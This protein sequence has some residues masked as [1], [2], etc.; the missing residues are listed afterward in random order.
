[1]L[2]TTSD[3]KA[4]YQKWSFPQALVS[5]FVFVV[6]FGLIV[7]RDV[8][9][10]IEPR[11][12]AEEATQYFRT[13]YT[14][15]VFNALIAPHQG[16]YSLW[17]NLAGVLATIPPLERAPDVTTGM[18][19]LVLLAILAAIMLN[20]SFALD[21]PLK[22]AIA[23]LSVV[24]VGATGEIWLTVTNSHY[25]FQLLLFVI[26]IDNKDNTVKRNLWYAT[27][28]VAGLS[29]PGANFL[30]PLFLLKYWRK[31]DRADLVLFLILAA[32]SVVQLLAVLYS[33]LIIKD[34]A[35]YGLRF[36]S[37]S[38]LPDSIYWILYYGTDYPIFG[39][40]LRGSQ[41]GGSWSALLGLPVSA[42]LLLSL[43][44]A[45]RRLN[46]YLE[47]PLAVLIL[48]SLSVLTSMGGR[49]G[50]RY[51]YSAAVIVA[52]QLLAQ[53]SDVKLNLG[54]RLIAGVLLL[55]SISYWCVDF[56]PGFQ[57]FHDQ[58]WPTWS[59][60]VRAWRADPSRNLQV[61]PIWED[62]T[63]AGV[64]W[65]LRLPPAN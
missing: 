6:V 65:T 34:Y 64:A 43:F 24:V 31:R 36:S 60:E 3:V 62:Q 54:A 58:R 33:D 26:L 42:A 38:N 19:L 9:L 61:W 47:F 32:T 21:F 51:A 17:E 7:F 44:L 48:T 52:L 63:A 29:S 25:Y 2:S 45:R 4:T 46:D 59:S 50:A 41:S 16:Y 12:W 8:S 13:A 28:V 22:K 10:F 57:Q 30:A 27:T 5:V 11:F 14:S 20:T 18:A 1:M 15:S 49:G 23:C 55:A 53:A 56:W 37:H 40:L 39:Y 35:Y